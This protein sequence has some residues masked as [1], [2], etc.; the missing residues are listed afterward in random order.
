[1]ASHQLTYTLLHLR[2]QGPSI[3][4]SGRRRQVIGAQGQ[5]IVQQLRFPESS[6]VAIDEL[7]EILL[8]LG[9]E[10]TMERPEQE[11]LKIRDGGVHFRQPLVEY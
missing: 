4:T 9:R 10:D 1:M 2:Q 3:E 7:V 6:I 5:K 8:Q 11:A